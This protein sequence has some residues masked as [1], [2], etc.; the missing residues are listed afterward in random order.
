MPKFIKFIATE[1]IWAFFTSEL[2]LTWITPIA[3]AAMIGMFAY[4][5]NFPIPL[6]YLATAMAVGFAATASGVLRLSEY[7]QRISIDGKL[8]FNMPELTIT[9]NEDK[10]TVAMI[11]LGFRLSSSADFPLDFWVTEIE[12]Q[13]DHRVPVETLGN[14]HSQVF[15]VP[16]R[17]LGTFRDGAITVDRKIDAPFEGKLRFKVNYKRPGSRKVAMVSKNLKIIVSPGVDQLLA[18]QHSEVEE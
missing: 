11:N 10:E 14:T 16:P 8:R 4:V 13:L 2:F 6:S 5:Q 1:I 17:G 12:T 15:Q 7:R 9:L 3:V 18:V